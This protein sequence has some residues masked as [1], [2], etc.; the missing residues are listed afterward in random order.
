MPSTAKIE[1][2][3]FT[4]EMDQMT[5]GQ[6]EARIA[7]LHAELTNLLAARECL[8]D[9]VAEIDDPSNVKLGTIHELLDGNPTSPE[10]QDL[11]KKIGGHL[12]KEFIQDEMDQ[13]VAEGKLTLDEDGYYR[14]AEPDNV[15]SIVPRTLQ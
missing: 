11:A 12:M 10:A 3:T 1:K 6:A 2:I 4:E 8:V 7:E 15:V 5:L 14:S 13:L 9:I